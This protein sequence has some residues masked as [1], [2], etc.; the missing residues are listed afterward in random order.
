MKYRRLGS[1]GVKVSTVALGSWLT[2][3]HAVDEDKTRRCVERAFELGIN[4]IDTADVYALG[5]CETVLGRVLEGKRRSDYVLAT[6]V[7]F[8]MGDGPN[9][10]GLSRKHIIESIE[11]SCRRLRT[12][13]VDLY[14]CHRHDPEVDVAEVVRTMN[15]LIRRGRIL[16]WGVSMWPAARIMEAVSLAR[17]EHL[18]PP[19]TNQPVYNLLQREIETEVLPVSDELGVGQIVYSPLAQGLLTGK[20]RGGRVPDDSR[21][22]DPRSNHF[23]KR[24]MTPENFER[25]D[26]LEG[27]AKELD[28]SLARLSLAF[29]LR[30]EGV[31]AVIVGATRP[32]QLTDNAGAVDIHLDAEVLQRIDAILLED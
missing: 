14:Q 15:D 5:A 9:D 25:I 26:R 20:Y 1:S 7:F 4:F 2:F 24:R 30:H 21:A 10:A 13:Y 27:L 23:M 6:K 12:D 28:T 18:E 11:A 32:D 17:A 29:C 16:Y 22:A 3:G 19:V 31:D 8:P